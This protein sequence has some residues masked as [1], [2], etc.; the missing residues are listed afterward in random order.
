MDYQGAKELHDL[1]FSFMGICHEKFILPFRSYYST[2][3][4]MKKNHIKII[5]VLYHHDYLTS[6][7]IGRKLDIEKGSLTALIDQLEN[8]KLVIRCQDTNDRRRTLISLSTKGR[9]EIEKM[10]AYHQHKISEL[11]TEVDPADT[12]Q[13]LI[14]LKSVIAFME[15]I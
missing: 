15:R 5:N 9:E 1:L 13:F 10:L 2:S 11:F 7:E 3:S 12:E 8:N 4:W 14:N 6:T